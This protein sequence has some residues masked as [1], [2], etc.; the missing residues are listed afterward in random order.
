MHI[1]TE[2]L[3]L[4]DFVVALLNWNIAKLLIFC[5][6]IFKQNFESI[7]VGRELRLKSVYPL[8]S[9]HYHPNILDE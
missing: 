4:F 6:E 5:A 1:L 9:V 8:S 7:Q 3:V 2:T